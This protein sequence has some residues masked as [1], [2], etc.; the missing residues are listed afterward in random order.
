MWKPLGVLSTIGL[1]LISLIAL[2]IAAWC[3][4][5]DNYNDVYNNEYAKDVRPM[6]NALRAVLACDLL[7]FIV[8]FV[9]IFFLVKP[10]PSASKCYI[11]M[12]LLVIVFKIVA[13]A[14]WYSGVNDTGKQVQSTMQTMWDNW[15]SGYDKT[16]SLN[17]WHA[18]RG[19]EI[20][21]IILFIVLGLIYAISVLKIS[22][23]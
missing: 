3:Y 9:G 22:S 12:V 20:A 15:P 10:N 14:L 1:L 19:A 8:S 16:D 13:G 18:E 11:V 21:S 4:D 23:G 2:A 7:M 6:V 5:K 17:A